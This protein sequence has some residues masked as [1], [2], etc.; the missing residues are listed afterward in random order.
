[1]LPEIL[2]KIDESCIF[3][4]DGHF[5]GGGTSKGELLTPILTEINTVLN[6]GQNRK[7]EHVILIDDARDFNGLND[8]PKIEEIQRLL[9]E[10]AP[11]YQMQVQDDIIMI[12]KT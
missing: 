11:G 12:D 7:L 3:W 4:L 9:K 8:Y 2:E 10:M 6:H 5:S 1:V